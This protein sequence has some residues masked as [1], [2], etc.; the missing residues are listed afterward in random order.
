MAGA[1]LRDLDQ[2]EVLEPALGI[3]EALHLLRHRAR[4]AVV[5]DPQPRRVVDELLV[6][7]AR[8]LLDL[9]RIG[10]ALDAQ[11]RS[12]EDLVLPVT[13]VRAIGREVRAGEPRGY[14]GA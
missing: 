7:P 2:R 14:A 10:G 1:L 6:G 13:P 12:V 4:V 8:L 3:G 11:E 9:L 5:H